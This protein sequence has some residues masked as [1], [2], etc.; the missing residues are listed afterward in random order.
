MQGKTPDNGGRIIHPTHI[1][2]DNVT[3]NG[4]D[5]EIGMFMFPLSNVAGDDEP[6][7]ADIVPNYGFGLRTVKIDPLSLKG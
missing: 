6:V 1:S 3:Y 4:A 5:K 2:V 7:F